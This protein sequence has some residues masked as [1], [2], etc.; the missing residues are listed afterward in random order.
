KQRMRN[1]AVSQRRGMAA[2]VRMRQR[3]DYTRAGAD[4]W[5]DIVTRTDDKHLRVSW[6]H[7]NGRA[8][9]LFSAPSSICYLSVW[10]PG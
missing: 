7:G 10:R 4:R 9:P 1:A 3:L 5:Q 6:Q 8:P 2:K